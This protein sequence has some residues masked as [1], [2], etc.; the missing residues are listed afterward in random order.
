M[1]HLAK[2]TIKKLP[3][4]LNDSGVKSLHVPDSYP[5]TA[6]TGKLEQ[7][8]CFLNSSRYGLFD[9]HINTPFEHIQGNFTVQVCRHHYCNQV[10][11][12]LLDHQSVICVASNMIS[13]H[14]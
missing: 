6:Y 12:R 9:E 1:K 13:T 2:R 10:G 4:Q 8:Q 7:L 3:L 11:M 5:C 14:C